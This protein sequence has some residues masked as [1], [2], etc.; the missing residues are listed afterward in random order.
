[1]AVGVDSAEFRPGRTSPVAYLVALQYLKAALSQQF[2]QAVCADARAA[3]TDHRFELRGITS[4]QIAC[5]RRDCRLRGGRHA[6]QGRQSPAHVY[7]ETN[8]LQTVR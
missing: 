7:L 4:R 1:M 2:A 8:L 6:W 5:G 3:R